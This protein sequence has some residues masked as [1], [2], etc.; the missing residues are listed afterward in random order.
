M[1]PWTLENF[2]ECLDRWI[3]LEKPIDELKLIVTAWVLT[4]FDDPYVG[5]RREAGFDNLWYATVP[6]TAHE[7]SI[8]VCSYW[9]FDRERRVRSDSIATLSLPL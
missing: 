7:G 1:S 3:D 8:V 6:R 5:V 2:E 9:I 4:R